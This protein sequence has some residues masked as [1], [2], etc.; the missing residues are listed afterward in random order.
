MKV[1][2][3][4]RRELRLRG[5]RGFARFVASRI[6]QPRAD[7]LFEIGLER[8]IVD[9]LD[10]LPAVIVNR[11]NAGTAEVAWIERQI[12]VD[13]NEDYGPG[14]KDRDWMFAGSDET[15]NVVAYAFVLFA[16]DYKNVLGVP[17][18]IP[19]IANCFTKPAWRGRHLYPRLLRRVCV[20]LAR[21][22]H[23]RAVISCAPDNV[24]SIRGIERAGFRRVARITCLSVLSKIVLLR[25]VER[26]AG[27]SG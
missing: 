18:D 1:V 3:R 9:A 15:R 6:V 11:S 23:K 24:A 5:L 10:P 16:T 27:E 17:E 21:A 25:R 13:H 4:L 20:E 12:L 8:E 22:G 26:Y 14:L 7:L 19:L 2:Q